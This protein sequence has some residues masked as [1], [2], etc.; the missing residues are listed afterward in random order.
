MHV[1]VILA[2]DWKD[3]SAF[4]RE[5]LRFA[6]GTRITICRKAN[7]P[8]DLLLFLRTLPERI[9]VFDGEDISPIVELLHQMGVS[10]MIHHYI[11]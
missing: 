10:V 4:A 8:S 2:N 11:R 9:V 3:N 6:D 1:L 5:I 7:T